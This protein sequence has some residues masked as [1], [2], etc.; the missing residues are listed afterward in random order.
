MDHLGAA[1]GP[2]LATGFLLL[3]PGELRALFL[4]TIVP[5]VLVVVL[6]VVGLREAPATEPP[7]ERV[8]LTPKPFDRNFRL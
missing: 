1:I 3:W 2:L 8:R 5:G 6:L 4:V 7:K